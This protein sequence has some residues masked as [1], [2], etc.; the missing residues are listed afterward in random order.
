MKQG[1]LI[2]GLLASFL[3]LTSANQF[4]QEVEQIVEGWL[5]DYDPKF[6]PNLGGKVH[7]WITFFVH[8]HII[9]N[10]AK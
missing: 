8:K 2:F 1:V 4:R 9:I 10:R 7:D 6:R 3:A 5:Q